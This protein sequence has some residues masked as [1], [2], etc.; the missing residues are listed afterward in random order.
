M[1]GTWTSCTAV[2]LCYSLYISCN[3]FPGTGRAST[4]DKYLPATSSFPV[5]T[6]SW[7]HKKLVFPC[8]SYTQRHTMKM[9]RCVSDPQS[10]VSE[11]SACDCGPLQTDSHQWRARWVV[12]TNGNLQRQR[13][14]TALNGRHEVHVICCYKAGIK[15]P[16]SVPTSLQSNTCITSDILVSKINPVSVLVF[17]LTE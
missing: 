10:V 16:L 11:C 15:K 14:W 3:L 9:I 6:F 12:M 13:G 1:F 5:S 8:K 7:K 2:L 4:K 17:I